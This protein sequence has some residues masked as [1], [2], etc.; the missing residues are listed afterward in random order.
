MLDDVDVKLL[1]LLIEDARMSLK[2][3][4]EKIGLSSPS[5]SERMRRLQERGVIRSYTIEIDPRALG[6][7]LEAI[8]RI[9]P[10]PG[11]LHLVQKLI[12]DIPEIT[13]CRKVTG[14]DCF[15]AHLALRSIDELD[16]IQT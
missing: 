2:D 13:Q 10:L 7:A 3:L 15:I 12:R 16:A 6:F 14:D 1:N 11:M 8:V 4:S 9:R 5:V